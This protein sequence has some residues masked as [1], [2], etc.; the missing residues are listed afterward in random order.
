ML[1]WEFPPENS[2]GLGVACFG[3]SKVLSQRGLD[4]TFILPKKTKVADDFIK[5]V[6][7]SL[8][9]F[10][11]NS[12]LAPY[13]YLSEHISRKNSRDYAGSLVQEVERY[14]KIA[15]RI[16]RGIS[17]D[18]IHANDW[19]SLKAGVLIKEASGKPLIAHIHA[20][21]FER[22][23]SDNVNPQVFE[24]EKEGLE[25]ADRII[26]VSNFTKNKIISGYKIDPDKISVVYNGYDHFNLEGGEENFN[27]ALGDK[28]VVLF[29]GRLSLHKG[30]D[31]FINAAKKV[32]EK[33]KDVIFIIAGKGEM[34]PA[35]V[36]QVASLGI[37]DKVL[38]AGFV[39]GKA[40]ERLYKRADVYVLSSV[41]EPFGIAPL[42]ALNCKTPVIISRQSGVSEVI[43]HAFK[44]DF[45]DTDELASKI[46]AVLSYKSLQKELSKNGY[47]EARNLTW[48]RAAD[49]IIKIYQNLVPAQQPG[50]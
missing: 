18:I 19:L 35:L 14:A 45:W 28:R 33:R 29:V 39:R 36:E 8:K 23:G 38:F 47:K 27:L 34:R 10:A 15:L 16:S 25:K 1:G 2:G 50:A 6:F 7:A 37:S 9:S 11:I 4:I 13:S 21:E 3:L 22:S 44:V 32:L 40:L 31:Y 42:E 46:L 20:T 48:D 30:P 12:P 26:A 24:I 41:S 43:H 17:F 5:V 49:Q